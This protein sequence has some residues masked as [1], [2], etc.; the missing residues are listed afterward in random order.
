MQIDDVPLATPGYQKDQKGAKKSTPCEHEAPPRHTLGTADSKPVPVAAQHPLPP[1]GPPVTST[2]AASV[3]TTTQSTSAKVAESD[4]S[5]DMP[6]IFIPG[7]R[8]PEM[9]KIH[10]PSTTVTSTTSTTSH[11]PSSLAEHGRAWL[12]QVLGIGKQHSKQCGKHIGEPSATQRSKRYRYLLDTEQF[13][14][15]FHFSGMFYLK[16]RKW[17]EPSCV[18]GL[19]VIY[20]R[21]FGI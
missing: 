5:P 1:T 11:I 15:N 8:E 16:L 3:V 2:T 12:A 4:P 6:R 9:E 20:L 17:L 21:L 7:T 18:L 19:I 13:S 10:T 14:N